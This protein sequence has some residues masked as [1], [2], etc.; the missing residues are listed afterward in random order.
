MSCFYCQE[1]KNLKL[2]PG[3]RRSRACCEDHLSIHRGK[4]GNNGGN[5]SVSSGYNSNASSRA[6]S[7]GS[8][9]NSRSRRTAGGGGH[10]V[11]ARGSKCF[12]FKIVK[13]E[14]KVGLAMSQEVANPLC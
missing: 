9:S 13:T 14:E 4:I 12:P 8:R 5:G 1:P 10:G 3:C 2:C 11:G 6:S 7:C